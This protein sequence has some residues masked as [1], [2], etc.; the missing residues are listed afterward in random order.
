[1]GSEFGR[2]KLEGVANV[3]GAKPKTDVGGAESNTVADVGGAKP[4]TDVGGAKSNTVADVGGAKPITKSEVRGAIPGAVADTEGAG[5]AGDDKSGLP[6]VVKEHKCIGGS[7]KGRLVQM[8]GRER[9][10]LEEDASKVNS[11]P[12]AEE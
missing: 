9:S 5:R 1:M 10:G 12:S 4:N 7:K 6:M 11:D 8:L 2:A 3:G